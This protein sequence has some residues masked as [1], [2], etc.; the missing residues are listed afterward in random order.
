M[1][2][3][4]L[5]LFKPTPVF[6]LA[7]EDTLQTWPWHPKSFGKDRDKVRA[8]EI[9]VADNG[10][11]AARSGFNPVLSSS[12]QCIHIVPW[13]V[14]DIV[15]IKSGM[16]VDSAASGS[17]RNFSRLNESIPTTN[18]FCFIL[19]LLFGKERAAF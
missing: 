5:L 2:R 8:G 6:V 12:N 7:F 3:D 17:L 9:K 15:D 4:D 14:P 18:T 10:M 1:T 13:H 11:D 19:T 16:K